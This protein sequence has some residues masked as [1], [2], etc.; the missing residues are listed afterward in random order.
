VSETI[1]IRKIRRPRNASTDVQINISKGANFWDFLNKDIRLGNS[2]LS[3]KLKESFYLELW[4]LVDAGVDIK[5]ALELVKQE[6]KKT[7]VRKVF[8]FVQNAIV[9][10]A[11][12]SSALKDAKEFS[13]YEYYSV[14]IGEETGKLLK[15]LKE[16]STYFG[17][18]IKQRRQ[19]IGAITY[20]LVV[21]VIA[22]AA[23]SFMVAYVVPMFADTFK[24]FGSD[25]PAITKVV[26]AVSGFIK[27]FIGVFLLALFGVIIFC[28]WQSKNKWFRKISSVLLLKMPVMGK[29]VQQIY[30]SRFS[31][32]LS[33]LIGAKIPLV[34]ALQLTRQMI[35]FY[36]IENSLNDIEE[37]ILSGIAFHKSL[38]CH[39]IYPSKMV[40]IV[41]VGEEVNQ[42]ELFFARLSEQYAAE[43]EYQA[44]MLSK[45][46]EPLIIVILG[47]IVGVI[48]IAMYLPLFR[49][50]QAF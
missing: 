21:L 2:K 47:L 49:L 22:F 43:V 23:V 3:D 42:L 29:M 25:L 1:D 35:S 39:A 26:I 33:L 17:K 44:T 7:K 15:V 37:K 50:G 27:S 28:A 34:Q 24:R 48:L 18:K 10:G 30:L 11:L 31:N 32:T 40:S 9:S 4:S 12:F 46:I 6:Q 16:L 41:K 13:A 38:A 8:E 19:I 45:F 36:P 20:P 5:T 14:Q